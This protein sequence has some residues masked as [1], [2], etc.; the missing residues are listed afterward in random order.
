ML[1]LYMGKLRHGQVGDLVTKASHMLPE[2]KNSDFPNPNYDYIQWMSSLVTKTWL[3]YRA[4]TYSRRHYSPHLPRSSV[5]MR[6][7]LS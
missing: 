4:S 5:E 1:I 3:S 2:G 6:N 7:E